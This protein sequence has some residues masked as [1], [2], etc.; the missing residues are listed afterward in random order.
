[1]S[2]FDQL[3][4]WVKED[5]KHLKAYFKAHENPFEKISTKLYGWFLKANQQP[6]GLNTY[7]EVTAWLLAYQKKYG[8][9]K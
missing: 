4:P 6:Q 8:L 2:N 7:D 1:K 9:P 3:H 5:L